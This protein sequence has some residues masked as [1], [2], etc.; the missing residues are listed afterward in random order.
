MRRKIISLILALVV[1]M[2]YQATMI[3]APIPLENPGTPV[4]RI[5]NLNVS[6]LPRGFRTSFD[7]F[8]DKK[9]KGELPTREGL[10]A[11]KISGSSQFSEKQLDRVISEIR[12]VHEGPIYILDLRQE[13]HGFLNG[14]A[15]SAYCDRDWVNVGKSVAQVEKEEKAWLMSSL[16]TPVEIAVLDE[17]KKPTNPQT[18][19]VERALAEKELITSRKINYFRIQATDHAPFTDKQVD[20]FVKFVKKEMPQNAWLHFHCEAGEGRTTQIMVMYDILRN[21]KNVSFDDIVKRQYLIGGNNAVKVTASKEKDAYKVPLYKEKAQMLRDF[22]EYITT[23]PEDLPLTFSQWKKANKAD[24]K[25]AI[26]DGLAN[27]QPAESPKK[28]KN[29]N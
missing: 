17:N 16:K 15:V 11:L 6:E 21:G 5:D 7:A 4:W 28:K 12:T 19:K 26:K 25:S 1:L 9:I 23:S 22:Y 2:A 14:I 3:A 13:S 18:I 8:K 10:F 24:D 20:Q 27:D 29:K